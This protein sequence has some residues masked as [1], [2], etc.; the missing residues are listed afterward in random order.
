MNLSWILNKEIL[1]MRKISY[2]GWWVLLFALILSSC[3]KLE[4]KGPEPV[5]M[6][7]EV[8]FTNV[9]EEGL[10]FSISPRIYWYGTDKDGFIVAYQY[11]VI[12]DSVWGV[13]GGLEEAKDSLKIGSDSASWVDNA[14]RLDAFG[15]HVPALKG[16]QREVRMYAEMDPED[17]TAQ[18]IFLRAVDNMGGLS[19]IKTRMYWRN[20]HTPQCSIEVDNTFVLESFY[21]LP[22]TTQTWK[23]IFISWVGL[24]TL[25]YPDKRKQPD[26]YYKWE[27]W[28]PYADTLPLDDDKAAI[29]DSSLDSIKI[30]GVWLYDRWILDK[31]HI[32]KNLE[33][34]PDSGYAWYQ[35]RVWSRDDAFVRSDDS[36]AT[37]FRILKPLFLFEEPS[38]KTIL[39]L[40][41]T[42]YKGV[43]RP[44][45]HSNVRPFYETALS[46]A[47]ICNDFNID[48]LGS[49]VPSED[50]LSRY[51]LVIVLNLGGG[52]G[53]SDGSYLK[54]KTYLDVGGRLWIIGLNNYKL[55]VSASRRIHYFEEMRTTAPHTY[56]VATE[57][58]GL[59]GVFSPQYVPTESDKLEFIKAEPFGSWDLPFLEMDPLKAAELED[60]DSTE[61][62]FNF[63][64]NGIPYVCYDVISTT[65]DFDKRTTLQR[66]L[67]SFISRRGLKSEMHLM[68]C[69]TTYIGPTFRTAEFPFPLNLMKDGDETNPG[70]Q[71]AFRK[72][73]EWF[74]EDLPE[75]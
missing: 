42:E 27:L 50:S 21:C 34:Y 73:V 61:P 71:E 29:V 24:D 48:S 59:E 3:G 54:Y 9:P 7:P 26:L 17:S 64:M 66:R 15:V 14:I 49:I 53:I 35:L 1:I 12:R 28:G 74:W 68:P 38:R 41:Q 22:E 32:F 65:L 10:K 37:F 20:N 4:R 2:L 43:G 46:E 60:Y 40:D 75:P 18:H 16:H 58:L 69:A 63:P 19:E 8:F 39:V 55:S 72:M 25:D 45:D 33:N 5:N 44:S 57:Y 23:G 47:G 51:D 31:S 62:G 13:W 36:A 67:Y 56:E 30:G 11:A 6:I 52:G 70:A